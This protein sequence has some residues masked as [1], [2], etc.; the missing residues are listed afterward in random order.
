MKTGTSIKRIR[1]ELDAFGPLVAGCTVKAYDR[2]DCQLA[3]DQLY[4]L[5]QRIKKELDSNNDLSKG[6]RDACHK[7]LEDCFLKELIGGLRV[8]GAHAVSD[9][10]RKQGAIA[11]RTPSGSPFAIPG[12]SS[13]GEVF[14]GPIFSFPESASVSSLCH[15]EYLAEAEKRI[16]KILTLANVKP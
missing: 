9:T 16:R 4:R 10:G 7:I 8:I 13:A 3:Y 1:D 14:A 11:L 5:W 15:S 12:D 6:D 2:K